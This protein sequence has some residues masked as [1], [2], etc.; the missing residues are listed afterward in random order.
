MVHDFAIIGGGVAGA[1]LAH[2]LNK[3]NANI[4]IIDAGSKL[5]GVVSSNRIDACLCETA[6]QSFQG[7]DSVS[8]LISDLGLEAIS[9]KAE[10]S[11][12]YIE[13]S[14]KLFPAPSGPG[15]FIS[16]DLL[17]V[18]AK[19]R[20]LFEPFIKKSN[21]EDES[22]C[23]FISRRF[24]AEFS[25]QLFTPLVNGIWAGDSS[26]LSMRSSFPAIWE[27]EK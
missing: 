12:K 10:F 8:E 18:S 17:S 16:S 21:L 27:M 19:F 2:F 24:G 22:V 3:K 9:P 5:G 11:R 26:K 25:K 23:D 20:A 14:G 4:C 7:N 1:S 6:A 13:T 15:S